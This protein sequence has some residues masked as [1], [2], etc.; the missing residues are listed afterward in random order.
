MSIGIYIIENTVTNDLYVGSSVS[1]IDERWRSHKRDLKANK[2]HS[3]RLQNS[4]NKYGSEVFQF[5]VLEICEKEDCIQREQ[6]FIDTLSPCFNMNPTAGNCSGRKFSEESKQKMSESAKKRGIHPSFLLNQVKT[7]ISPRKKQRSRVVAGAK[8]TY[9]K[10]LS[11]GEVTGYNETEE[12]K[13]ESTREASRFFKAKGLKFN[14]R[15]LAHNINKD[16]MYYGY[17]WKRNA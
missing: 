12:L 5:R 1:D 3:S 6:L 15:S 17:Y 10:S 4:W 8:A 14:H 13:F 11:L 16:R 7:G 9:F 2:H